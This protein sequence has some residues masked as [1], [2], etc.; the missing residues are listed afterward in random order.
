M[1]KLWMVLAFLALN[2]L[3][4]GGDTAIAPPATPLRAP[5]DRREYRHL[6]LENGLRVLLCSEPDSSIAGAAVAVGAGHYDDPSSRPGLAHYVEHLLFL[7]S[8]KYPEES[9]FQR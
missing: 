8:E 4:R 3:A 6:V 9:G 5:D 1:A 7:G 2:L